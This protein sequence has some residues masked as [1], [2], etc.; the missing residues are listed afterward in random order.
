[1]A[2]FG[3]AGMRLAHMQCPCVTH[4]HTHT[5]TETGT[6]RASCEAACLDAVTA[7][8]LAYALR[9]HLEQ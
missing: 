4:T 3:T 8:M 7:M 2:M 9:C 1:M 6:E 5:H